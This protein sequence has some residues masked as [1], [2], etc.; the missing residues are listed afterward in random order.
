MYLEDNHT[1]FYDKNPVALHACAYLH[2]YQFVPGDA[3]Q[4]EKFSN[5]LANFPAFSQDDVDGLVDFL[6]PKLSKGDGASVLGRIDSGSY[7]P[8]KKLLDHVASLIQGARDYILLDEQL[9]VFDQVMHMVRTAQKKK[10]KTVVL[11]KGGPGSGKSLIAMNLIGTLS[12]EGFN[13]HYVTGSKAFTETLRNVIGPRGSSQFKY[14]NSYAA[15]AL[16]AID[17]LICDE[18]H[19]I[20]ITSNNRFTPKTKRSNSPQV[21]ELLKAGR[22]SVFFIDDLQ[23]VRPEEIG[24]SHYI[25]QEAEAAGH[26]VFEYE[27]EGQFRCAGADGFINWVDNTLGIRRTANVLWNLEEEF[28]LRIFDSPRNLRQAIRAKIADGK[29]ARLSAGFCWP[30]SDP[31]SDGT[32]VADVVIDGFKRPWNAKPDAGRLAAGIPKSSL[33]AH[34]PH[35]ID[36]IGCIYTAQGFEFDYI[37]VIFGSDLIFN[38]VTGKWDGNPKASYDKKVKPSKSDFVRYVKNAY[39][40]LMT[41]GMR[42]CFVCFLNRDSENFV[43]SRL[44]GT[45]T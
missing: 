18:A 23:L 40:V 45:R 39:R 21:Q 17:V 43:R 24:S 26:S 33:W 35:G 16:N 37:G 27:L 10:G 30:W 5:W 19:R 31:N 7:R 25:K 29:T 9:V 38:P 34:D 11:I 2:N 14:F 13:A 22:T 15:S 4:S 41:R 28:E 8:C 12:K 36:Q 3:L 1:A 20:R 32:L 44:E 42:G 6:Q